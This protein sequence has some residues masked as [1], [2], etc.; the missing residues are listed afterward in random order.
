MNNIFA[1]GDSIMKGIVTNASQ[2]DNGTVK[3]IISDHGFVN[4]VGCSSGLNIRNL[5]RFGS[6]ILGGLNN[7]DRHLHEIKHGDRVVLEFGGNDC[8]FDW[9][10]ISAN[11]TGIHTP[12][13]SLSQFHEL[14]VKLIEKVRSVGAV[15]VLLSLPALLPQRF[16]DFVSKGLNKD[17][18]LKWLGGDVN[19]ISNW[20]EQYN[21]EIFKLAAQY[22]VQVIDITTV[23]LERRT[24]GDFYCV[25]GMHPN[26]AG[27]ELIAE[28]ILSLGLLP[29]AS[30]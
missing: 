30:C 2:I 14:Y 27:H 17:N 3:Y 11:P 8:N 22:N 20:H 28:T 5:S 16:F 7:I 29:M 6:T 12:E 10:A 19:Y 23:F 26:E 24:L 15:P 21:L 4:R 13:I 9:K 1:F 18:I 25:D